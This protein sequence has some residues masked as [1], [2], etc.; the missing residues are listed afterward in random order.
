VVE[1]APAEPLGPGDWIRALGRLS[2]AAGVAIY[3]DSYPNYVEGNTW[4]PRS[5]FAISGKVSVARALN[6]LCYPI[7]NRSAK[8]LFVNSFWW[9]RGNAA[10]VRSRRWLWESAAVLPADLLD[11][12]TAS[13]R[14]TGQI[15]PRDLPAIASLTA[16]QFQS[17]GFL[18]GEWDTWRLAVQ[19]PAQLSL[20]SR[21]LLLTSGLTWEKMPPADRALLERLLSRPP[22]GALSRYA[23]RLK[24]AIGSNPAQGGTLASL[25]FEA[26]GEVGTDQSFLYF[27]LPGVSGAP[28]LP[29][30]GLQ[31]MLVS[32]EKPPVETPQSR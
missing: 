14:A 20:E 13:L 9:R 11:R 5:D 27:P 23:A 1:V 8:K 7:A 22:G 29:P 24:T 10:L 4:H 30:Y 28:G 21:K 16:M 31:V 25:T 26:T 32:R 12:L 3:A 2:D 19:L 15:D 6:R 17:I 18:D